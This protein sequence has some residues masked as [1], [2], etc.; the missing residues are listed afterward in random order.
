MKI[1]KASIKNKSK[2]NLLATLRQN[3]RFLMHNKLITIKIIAL[4][5][6]I[7]GCANTTNYTPTE[8][9]PT[10]QEEKKVKIQ[11]SEFE[12]NIEFIGI[13][14]YNVGPY[15]RDLGYSF[16]RSW[17]FKDTGGI[18]HQLYIRDEYSAE[19]WRNWRTASTEDAE[20][21]E[22]TNIGSDVESCSHSKYSKSSC[23]YEESFGIDISSINLQDKINTGFRIKVY[24][25]NGENMVIQVTPKQ[26]KLQLEAI[27][28]KSKYL[29][30][31]TDTV[32]SGN[33]PSMITVT[34]S[35]VGCK[36]IND[37]AKMANYLSKKNIKGM[38]KYALKNNCKPITASTKV[39]LESAYPKDL[40]I[41]AIQIR[42]VGDSDPIWTF[43]NT[44]DY[45]E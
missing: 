27:A 33:A 30:K 6:L 16:I 42:I 39:I 2:I 11:D 29:K 17:L 24:A 15:G 12:K 3:M 10:I 44:T 28:S 25:K 35:T 45:T 31:S 22:I 26:I 1:K 13:S 14:D 21:L 19:N 43:K 36:D 32:T 9:T 18:A 7:S 38:V 5:I 23:R 4:L 20:M 37:L 34:G 41:N 8:Y 40:N